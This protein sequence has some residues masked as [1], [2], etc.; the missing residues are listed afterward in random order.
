MDIKEKIEEGG[1]I[2]AHW[3]GTPE[4]EERIKPCRDIEGLPKGD[5]A[6]VALLGRITL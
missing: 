6:M 4:T 2:L 3:D 5:E 1:F